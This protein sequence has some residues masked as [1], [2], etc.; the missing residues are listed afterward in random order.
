MVDSPEILARFR[1]DAD[2]V[3]IAAKQIARRVGHAVPLEDLQ[4]FGSEGLLQAARSFDESRGVPFRRWANVRIKGA[5][6]D[7]VR[8]WGH[9]PRRVYRE[10]QGIEAGDRIV[11][12]YDEEYCANPATT[13]EM[14]DDRLNTY[15]TGIATAIAV[16]TMMGAPRE[17]VDADGNDVTPEDLLA[18]A[19]F[20]ERVK[21]IVAELPERER[22]LIDRHYF[23]GQT[24][25]DAAASL[26]LS[27]SWGS[28]LH[29]RII[30]TICKELRKSGDL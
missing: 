19:E 3:T 27:K 23:A 16:G 7:G 15:L 1:G 12:T 21:T 30:E 6:I 28:R 13:P 25:D 11:E 17:N 24:L 2:L 5:I 8:K 18:N 29:A 14:A 20:I 22:A 10:L 9:L 4:S 26:G